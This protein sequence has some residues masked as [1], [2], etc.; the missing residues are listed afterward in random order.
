MSLFECGDQQVGFVGEF[1]STLKVAFLQRTRRLIQ[2]GLGLGEGPPLGSGEG[3]AFKLGNAQGHI[4]LCRLNVVAK[5]RPPSAISGFER[6][7]AD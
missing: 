6:R 5:T 7:N 4:S 2:E 3:M 1:L